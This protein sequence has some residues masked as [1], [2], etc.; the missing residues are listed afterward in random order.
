MKCPIVKYRGEFWLVILIF[1]FNC[2]SVNAQPK[3]NYKWPKTMKSNSV[4]DKFK[5]SDAVILEKRIFRTLSAQHS[6]LHQLEEGYHRVKINTRTG[7]DLYNKFIVPEGKNERISLLDARVIKPDGQIIDLNH[8]DI[9]KINYYNEFD[10]FRTDKYLIFSA[11]GVQKGD[12]FEYA[13]V[14]SGYEVETGNIMMAEKLPVLSNTFELIINNGLQVEFKNYNQVPAPVVKSKLNETTIRWEVKNQMGSDGGSY[15][16]KT[17]TQPYFCLN[18]V[19]LRDVNNWKQYLIKLNN[20]YLKIINRNQKSV[21]NS[22]QEINAS[23]R[24]LPTI[25][26]IHNFHEFM[27]QNYEI[28]ALKNS[29]RS[30]GVDYFIDKMSSD[31]QALL[32]IYKDYLLQT[33]AKIY[34]GVGKNRYDGELDITFPTSSQVTHLFFVIEDELGRF[35]YLFP[36]KF[37]KQYSKDQIP[38]VLQGTKALIYG[39]QPKSELKWI[40]LPRSPYTKNTINRRF[41]LNIGSDG[42]VTECQGALHI[43]GNGLEIHHRALTNEL[44]KTKGNERLQELL[45]AQFGGAAKHLKTQDAEKIGHYPFSNSEQLDVKVSKDSLIRINLASLIRHPLLKLKRQMDSVEWC[46]L[47]NGID[48]FTFYLNFD[49]PVEMLNE[50]DLV[51]NIENTVGK[52]ALEI[53]NIGSNTIQLHSRYILKKGTLNNSDLEDLNKINAVAF[54][55]QSAQVY[56]KAR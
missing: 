49:R 43:A 5:K 25:T 3:K 54:E 44:Y 8:A 56:L 30:G 11:P 26:Q 15:Q 24:N 46:P 41:E 23:V 7:A 12:I 37:Q 16:I 34:I 6:Q 28:R 20:S 39:I 2:F 29:E 52:Y 36:K 18:T 33:D 13:Y 19:M 4:P 32:K 27:N 10:P 55:A 50:K 42:E 45:R 1:S 48:Q 17:S 22:Y 35:S 14:R 47:L 53:R 31:Q 9:K 51:Q 21:N 40:S 38:I